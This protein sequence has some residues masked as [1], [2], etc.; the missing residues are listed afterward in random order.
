ML[1]MW[2]EYQTSTIVRSNCVWMKCHYISL[3]QWLQVSSLRKEDC[4]WFDGPATE[5]EEPIIFQCPKN[6]YMA[7]VRSDFDFDASDRS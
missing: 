3:Q 4:T 6:Q 5:L 2:W 1:F 7:G